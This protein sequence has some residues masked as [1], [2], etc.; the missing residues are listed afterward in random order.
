[1]DLE[2]FRAACQRTGR[3]K[4]LAKTPAA[5]STGVANTTTTLGIILAIRAIFPLEKFAE[6]LDRLNRETPGV[7]WPDMVWRSFPQE[8]DP[9]PDHPDGFEGVPYSSASRSDE[10]R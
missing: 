5:R 6:E 3:A 9:R 7:Q 1:M 4:T 10:N 8:R 2:Q